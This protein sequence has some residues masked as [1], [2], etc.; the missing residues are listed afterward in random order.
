MTSGKE[1]GNEETDYGRDR[2][3]WEGCENG[4]LREV[5]LEK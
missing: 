1:K 5:F 4:V 2:E 3:C